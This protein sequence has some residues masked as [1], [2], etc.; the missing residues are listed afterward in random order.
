MRHGY[1]FFVH[2][3]SVIFLYAFFHLTCAGI[4]MGV[5]GVFTKEMLVVRCLSGIYNTNVAS[6]EYTHGDGQSYDTR[7]KKIHHDLFQSFVTFSGD[8]L[9][10][11]SEIQY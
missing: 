4:K 1:P 2:I 6:I 10:R 8:G 7:K 5:I 3:F 11:M 9:S